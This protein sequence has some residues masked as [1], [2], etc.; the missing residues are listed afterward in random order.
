MDNLC[1]FSHN[2]GIIVEFFHLCFIIMAFLKGMKEM[3]NS[4]EAPSSSDLLH[5]IL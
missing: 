3:K 4:F 5:K 2:I 1:Y